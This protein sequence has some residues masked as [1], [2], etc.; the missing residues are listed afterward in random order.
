MPSLQDSFTFKKRE[1]DVSDLSDSWRSNVFHNQH[2]INQ[3]NLFPFSHPSSERIVII[4][5]IGG[6]GGDDSIGGK[7]KFNN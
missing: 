6:D 2:Q 4:T 1:T 7:E 3:I 5:K